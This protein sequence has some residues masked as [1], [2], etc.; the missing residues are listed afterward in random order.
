MHKYNLTIAGATLRNELRLDWGALGFE[1]TEDEK[2]PHDAADVIKTDVLLMDISAPSKHSKHDGA[3]LIAIAES[4]DIRL[5]KEAF[6]LGAL[7]FVVMPVKQADLSEA[8][9]RAK[10]ALDA[11][12]EQRRATDVLKENY[13]KTLPVMRERFLNMLLWGTLSSDE[14]NRQIALYNLPFGKSQYKGVIVFEPETGLRDTVLSR[15]TAVILIMQAIREGLS[16]H[17]KNVVFL[18][19]QSF[20]A[21]TAWDEPG[22][23]PASLAASDEICAKCLETLDIRL[24]AGIGNCYDGAEM[25]HKSFAEAA[26]ALAYREAAGSARA[27]Y[28]GDVEHQYTGIA[29]NDDRCTERLFYAVKFGSE[30]QITLIADEIFNRLQTLGKWEKHAYILNV[31]NELFGIIGRYELYNENAVLEALEPFI[32]AAIL[33]GEFMRGRFLELCSSI[34]GHIKSRRDGA[35]YNLAKEAK[36]FIDAHYS[37]S[38]LTV[39]RVCAHLHISQSYFSTVFK[40]EIGVGFSKYITELR[41]SRAVALLLQTNDK[42]QIIASKVGYEDPNYFCYVF[43]RRFG[44]SPAQYKKTK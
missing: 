40:A 8:L 16:R 12:Y 34:G 33:P 5:V 19:S 18:S 13:E 39:A 32:E 28:I 26:E 15:E 29:P 11:A 20:V 31:F 35:R 42:A 21:I 37:E 30:T 17:C 23:S 27:I 3:K 22:Y 9:I 2:D 1:L 25:L 4:S 7:D 43:K 38:D 41:M 6:R 36:R 24:T 44:V 14:I 10:R